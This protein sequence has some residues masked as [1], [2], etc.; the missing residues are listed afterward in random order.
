MIDKIAD[1]SPEVALD[2]VAGYLK[3]PM[4]TEL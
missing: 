1:K 4:N 2:I 3:N